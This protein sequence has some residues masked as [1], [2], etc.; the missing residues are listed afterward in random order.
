MD[1]IEQIK[2]VVDKTQAEL[3]AFVVKA[4]EQLAQQGTIQ[5]ETTKAIGDLQSR[6]EELGKQLS[7]EKSKEAKKTFADS[8]KESEDFQRLSRDGSG[9]ARLKFH[10]GISELEQKTAITSSAVGS[11]TSGVLLTDRM[12]GVVMQA[13]KKL[14]I[15][16]LLPSA[17]TTDNAIDFV[18]V[19]AFTSAASPQVEASSKAESALTFTTGT[20]SVR[21]LAHWIPASKQILADFAGLEQIIRDELIYGLKDKEEQEILSGDGTG[22]HLSGL[23]TNATAFN[24]ALLSASNGW[25]KV[26]ILARSMQQVEVANETPAEWFVLN[27]ADWYDIVLNK[28][29]DGQYI[30]GNAY[31]ILTPTLWGKRVLVTNNITSGSFL[32]GNSRGSVIRDR[33]GVTVEISTEH[34]TYFVENMVA[35]RCEERLALPIMRPASYIT[36]SLTT[37]PA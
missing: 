19:N 35:I 22:Q 16:D 10:G 23:I 21:T 25:E 9:K 31:S 27:P 33:E 17:G 7:A 8:L 13:M 24:T 1:P 2:S 11:M 3:N 5:T 14:F 20:A 32:S 30:A 29:T 28:A 4:Q 34:S 18:K 36:G 15:R 6:I 12:P 26:D 37:S